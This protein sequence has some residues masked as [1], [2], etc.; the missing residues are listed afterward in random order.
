[1]NVYKFTKDK[2]NFK[3]V[4]ANSVGEA[5]EHIDNFEYNSV[6]VLYRDVIV[7]NNNINKTL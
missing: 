7:C 1:M 4:I 3:I 2:N 6:K 5:E